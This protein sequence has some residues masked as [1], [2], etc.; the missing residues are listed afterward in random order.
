MEPRGYRQVDVQGRLLAGTVSVQETAEG[1]TPWRIPYEQV[2]L[3]PP[4]PGIEGT[5]HM[6]AGVRIR[7]RSDTRRVNLTVAAM[8]T[9]RGFDLVADG[10]LVETAW[11][12]AGHEEVAFH[13]LSNGEKTVEIWLP[14]GAP[15]RLESLS[16]DKA[17]TFASAARKSPRWTTYGSSITHCL[18]A[19]SPA[20]TWP[21]LVARQHGLDLTCLG[22]SGNCH[23]EPMLGRLIRDLPADLITLKVGANVLG[24]TLSLRTFKPAVIG[25]IMLI[26]EKHPH[27]PM[28]VVS[29]VSS[30]RPGEDQD[31]A[32]GL[33]LQKMRPEVEDAVRRVQDYGD[34]RLYYVDG[35]ALLGPQE[36]STCLA[37]GLHPNPEGYALIAERF[38]HIVFGRLGI[39]PDQQAAH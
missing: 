8:E 33:C 34:T 35:T 5:G 14:Q 28:V 36:T 18:G 10:A 30:A 38:G 39:C 9:R 31:N 29:P 13:G 37:D 17:A 26:R 22:F 4:D 3:F 7:F 16:I 27:T 15:V 21:A 6:A 25:L 2:R 24:G 1:V 32:V 19:A 12:E 20:R 23:L 11:L